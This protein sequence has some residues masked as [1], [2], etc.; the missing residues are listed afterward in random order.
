LSPHL[1]KH[2]ESP[3]TTLVSSLN[4]IKHRRNRRKFGLYEREREKTRAKLYFNLS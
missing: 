2:V 4:G 1:K 3:P